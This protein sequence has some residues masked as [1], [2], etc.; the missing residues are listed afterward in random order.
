MEMAFIFVAIYQIYEKLYRCAI[1]EPL[2]KAYGCV[3]SIP[4][5]IRTS[6]ICRQCKNASSVVKEVKSLDVKSSTDIL[7]Q[8][9]P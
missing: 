2:E 5:L 1:I 6:Y 8:Q 4:L 3:D 9:D 7:D